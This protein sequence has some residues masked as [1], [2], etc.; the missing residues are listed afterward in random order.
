MVLIFDLGFG[1]CSAILQAPVHWL[2]AFIDVTT[3]EK[4][5]ERAR[6]SRNIEVVGHYNPLTDPA[7]VKLEHSRIDHWTKNGAQMSDTVARLVKSNPLPAVGAPL[8]TESNRS[9]ESPHTPAAE[10]AA[11]AIDCTSAAG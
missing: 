6:D 9:I 11:S 2:E 4:F 5:H 10:F 7:T 3:I 1:Q 8:S